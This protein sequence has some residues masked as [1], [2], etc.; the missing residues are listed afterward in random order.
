MSP[1]GDGMAERTPDEWLD[2]LAGRLDEQA[3][4]ASLRRRYVDGNAP[5][6][7]MGRNLRASWE[8]FQRKS[9][10]NWGLLVCGS[11]ADRIIY[12]G[13]TV[14]G[15]TDSPEAVLAA[16]I[17]RDNRLPVVV[18]DA[19]WDAIVTGAGYLVVGEQGGRAVVTAE[20][21][22]TTITAHNP[23]QPWKADA[24]LK[25]SRNGDKIDRATMWLPG[26]V[27]HF[28]RSEGLLSQT[29][30]GDWTM[31]GSEP[32]AL[33]VP[34]FEL[35]HGGGELD[36]HTDLIDRI[37]LVMLWRLVIQSMQAFRQ[38]GLKSQEG[39][40]GLP[41][42]DEEGNPIDWAAA[43]APAPGALWEFPPGIEVWESGQTDIRPMLDSV[44]AD[45]THLAT[46]TKTPLFIML[47]DS[48]NQSG[49]GADGAKDALAAKARKFIRRQSLAIEGALLAAMRAEGVAEPPT[50]EVTF[51]PA[52]R[53]TLAEKAD[54]AL[55]MQSLM[56][57]KT[58]QKKYLG[59]SP[60]EI[61]ADEAERR[62]Q[63][64]QNAMAAL[65]A[66][67]PQQAAEAPPEAA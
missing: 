27:Y 26:V 30:R 64:A 31:V 23:L 34:V 44:K 17:A 56:S 32:H 67:Q 50:I 21:P 39:S 8:A 40:E 11:M 22:E 3:R 42:H 61:A 9:R 14:G 2:E 43:L 66:P 48:V 46:V 38:R 35:S 49:S 57:L 41:E 1:E 33:G 47:P 58:I 18:E 6:P 54:A 4:T 36:T 25:V 65:T 28:E 60:D 29:N 63:A 55:K 52:E 59:W 10:T 62:R 5:L 7:E 51:E 45:V 13:V 37:N 20:K 12:N 15:A 19:V 53:V 24:A 16:R